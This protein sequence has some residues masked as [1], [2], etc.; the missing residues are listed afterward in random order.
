M[1]T[2]RVTVR[3]AVSLTALAALVAAGFRS[4]AGKAP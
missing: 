2:S 1:R 4:R 3:T